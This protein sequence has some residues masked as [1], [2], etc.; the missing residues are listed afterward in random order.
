MKGIDVQ[1]GE[2]FGANLIGFENAILIGGN[3]N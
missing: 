1:V 3:L 2:I